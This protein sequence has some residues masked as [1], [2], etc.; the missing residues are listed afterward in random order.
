[1]EDTRERRRSGVTWVTRRPGGVHDP[2]NVPGI[3]AVVKY[4]VAHGGLGA[5]GACPSSTRPR[6]RQAEARTI[7]GSA[8]GQVSSFPLSRTAR[9]THVAAYSADSIAPST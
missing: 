9:C 7:A 2:K 8:S 4:L 5:A 6:D 1:M 3:A